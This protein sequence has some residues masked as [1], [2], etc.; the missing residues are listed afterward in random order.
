MTDQRIGNG[1]QAP[2]AGERWQRQR[3]GQRPPPP[4]VKKIHRRQANEVGTW[5]LPDHSRRRYN[6]CLRIIHPQRGVNHLTGHVW[7]W[8]P[9]DLR[10][11]Y[12]ESTQPHRQIGIHIGHLKTRLLVTGPGESQALLPG[13]HSPLPEGPSIS[14]FSWSARDLD[15]RGLL[16]TCPLTRR[17]RPPNDRRL[18][19][20]LDIGW[21][22]SPP[23]LGRLRLLLLA[24]IVG[25][26]DPDL[27]HG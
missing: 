6:F 2:P 18:V 5:R 9:S 17:T 22:P 12:G 27:G 19:L 3:E 8:S 16:G 10:F 24:H 11:T 7:T 4:Q 14:Q 26:S 1:L 15:A 21:I 20:L 13:L 25:P 23:L